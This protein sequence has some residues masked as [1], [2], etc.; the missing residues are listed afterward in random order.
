MIPT[1]RMKFDD[2]VWGEALEQRGKT[3]HV[4]AVILRYLYGL[5]RDMFSGQLTL[6]AMSLV[7]TTLLSIVPLIAFSFSVLQGFGVHNRLEP[8]LYELLA[9]LGNRGAEITKEI[10]N[11]VDGVRGGVLGGI[12]L[13]FFIYTAV[14][15]VQKVEESF[16][17]VWY[18]AK[19]RSLAKRLTHYMIVLLIGPVVIVIALGMI[20][21]LRSTTAV[22]FF[23]TAEALGPVFVATSKLTPYLLV[24]AVF[25]FLY[26]YMPN[27]RVRFKSALVGGIA[28]G[29]IWA[30]L[31]T[32]FTTFVVF[33]TRTQ[34]IYSGFAVAIIA[35]IWLY[36]NWLVLLIGAQLAYYFQNP[37]FLRIGRREPRL[38]N[39]MRERLA[40]NVMLLVGRAFRD[41]D[42]SI[43]MGEISKELRMP[44]IALAPV[45]TALDQAGL[46]AA[47]EKE[48][49]LPGRDISTIRLDDILS[50]V[51]VHGE[52]G[53]YRDPKWSSEI[54]TLGKDLDDSILTTVGTRTLIDLLEPAAGE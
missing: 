10:I 46:L 41:P 44:S 2:L 9:P 14:S 54:D 13:A 19:P 53:S 51:R 24:V 40:L 17:Y 22:Q 47:T 28:G 16:N 5:I 23:L 31:S 39:S 52:T 26:M 8:L 50:V 38:S 42:Q 30:T 7:Y 33:S 1:L 36:L 12:S 6:R 11:L 15:M 43:T 48:D 21:S 32:I 29:F 37:A 3:G 45:V 20:A 18:V 4:L 35:L 34:L 27:T 25:T 49:L